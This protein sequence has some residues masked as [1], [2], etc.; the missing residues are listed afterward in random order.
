MPSKTRPTYLFLHKR[1]GVTT[2]TRLKHTYNC[3][4][5]YIYRFL[6]KN[7]KII[8]KYKVLPRQLLI[9]KHFF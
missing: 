6:C 9:W 5:I 7:K 4:A 2:Q 8:Y 1:L 3:V